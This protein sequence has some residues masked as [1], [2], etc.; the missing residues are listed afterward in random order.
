MP[1]ALSCTASSH[2]ISGAETP[3]R[4]RSVSQE[5]LFFVTKRE[6]GGEGFPNRNAFEIALV[7][8]RKITSWF[9]TLSH[10]LLPLPSTEERLVVGCA[11]SFFEREKK[12]TEK[13]KKI[14]KSFQTFSFVSF[15]FLWIH[16][17]LR[18]LTS[19]TV[20]DS[21]KSLATSDEVW[22]W[23]DL[24]H[25]IARLSLTPFSILYLGNMS[26]SRAIRPQAGCRQEDHY[27][28]PGPRTLDFHQFQK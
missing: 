3:R 24:S 4:K 17:R 15:L 19:V 18:L 11:F 12:D 14:E 13:W 28:R 25:H 23:I 9:I 6:W 10:C 5:E 22:D 7:F 16:L 21:V 20:G 27:P 26:R 1:L 2:R 8:E